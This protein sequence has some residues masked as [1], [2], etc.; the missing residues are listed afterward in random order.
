MYFFNVK[1]TIIIFMLLSQI[2]WAIPK[3]V[4]SLESIKK[5][6]VLT[7]CSQAGFIPFEYKNNKGV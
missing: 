6:G 3:N 4:N 7:V 5:L 2:S 1:L